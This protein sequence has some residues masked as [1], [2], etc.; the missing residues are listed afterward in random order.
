MTPTLIYLSGVA[1]G[2][3]LLGVAGLLLVGRCVSGDK[4][5]DS[6]HTDL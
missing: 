4:A 6:E 3:I 1:T 5:N 2:I